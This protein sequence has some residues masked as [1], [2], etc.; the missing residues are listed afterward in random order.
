MFRKLTIPS[1]FVFFVA[2]TFEMKK[3]ETKA[4]FSP[5]MISK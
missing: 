4:Q 3:E 2:R 1:A 5:F